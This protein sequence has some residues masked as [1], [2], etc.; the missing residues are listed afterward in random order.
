VFDS[1]DLCNFCLLL[2]D[3]DEVL[4]FF[5]SG[6]PFPLLE[7][8]GVPLTEPVE[9]GELPFELVDGADSVGASFPPFPD[10]FGFVGISPFE[11]AGEGGAEGSSVSISS[12]GAGDGS[13]VFVFLT[14]ESVGG[15][16]STSGA[17]GDTVGSA[18]GSSVSITGG[19]VGSLSV[20]VF[21][22]ASVI[23]T[24]AAVGASVSAKAGVVVGAAVGTSV[25]ARAGVVVG[26]VVEAMG[27][28]VGGPVVP[29]TGE[30]VGPPA[31]SLKLARYLLKEKMDPSALLTNTQVTSNTTSSTGASKRTVDVIF[32]LTSLSKW[33]VPTTGASHT[34]ATFIFSSGVNTPTVSTPSGASTRKSAPRKGNSKVSTS[35]V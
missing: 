1:L 21:V 4:D 35:I 9:V 7:L 11:G 6:V 31:A 16:V 24:G 8:D 5:F 22:G 27:D 28:D 18:V 34:A 26:A 32:V 13:L 30:T 15:S 10:F 3:E 19:S 2:F 12:T 29:T 17:T 20:G 33:V 14:G 23:K 25:S